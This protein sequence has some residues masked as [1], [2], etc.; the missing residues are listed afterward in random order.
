MPP[1]PSWVHYDDDQKRIYTSPLEVEAQFAIR[2]GD[3]IQ[4]DYLEQIHNAMDDIITTI[5]Y[6]L[7]HST[8]EEAV[9]CDVLNISYSV[10]IDS[11]CMQSIIV[12]PCAEGLGL[13]KIILFFFMHACG[14]RGVR[15]LINPESAKIRSLLLTVSHC[16]QIRKVLLNKQWQTMWVL[17]PIFSRAVTAKQCRI[18][19]KFDYNERDFAYYINA[20]LF[21]IFSDLNDAVKM[22]ARKPIKAVV[23]ALQKKSK[24]RHICYD[25]CDLFCC[26]CR[27]FI[28]Q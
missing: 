16:F 22:E 1:V 9:L 12:R 15:L 27:H 5:N 10:Q 18:L 3:L 28:K 2:S 23:S 8:E 17:Q 6:N 20:E 13:F 14:R 11:V 26:C 19:G 7:F 24:K 25:I 4:P 21:P